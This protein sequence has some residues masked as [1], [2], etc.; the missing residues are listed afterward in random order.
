MVYCYI[1]YDYKSALESILPCI[2]KKPTMAEF[3]CLLAD[4][5]YA[6]KDYEKAKSFYENAIILG[7]KRLRSDEW[8]LEVSKYK[9]Y[10]QKMIDSC[11]KIKQSSHVYTN[12]HHF[13]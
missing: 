9:D 1:K 4:I 3:W 8:P 7:G 10:P 13:A 11:E 5:Y 2:A 6:T 12:R